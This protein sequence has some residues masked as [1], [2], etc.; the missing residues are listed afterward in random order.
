MR[1]RTL[2]MA[3]AG[4][5]LV[6][7]GASIAVDNLGGARAEGEQ[8]QDPI[9]VPQSTAEVTKKDLDAAVKAPGKLGFAEGRK[10]SSAGSGVLTWI[11]EG[12]KQVDRGGKLYEVDAKGVYLMIG[13]KPMYRELKLGNKGE[14]V[15]QLKQN[16]KALGH[17]PDLVADDEFTPGTRVAVQNWQEDHGLKQTG[18][19]GPEQIV[20]A[21]GPLRAGKPEAALGD[22]LAPGKPVYTASGAERIAEMQVT[23][24]EAGQRKVGDKVTVQLPDGSTAPGKI[25]SVGT[26]AEAPD[27]ETGGG[28]G[29]GKNAK[30]TITIELDKPG[31]VKGVDQAPVTVSMSGESRQDVLSVPVQALIALPGQGFGVQVVKD[32]KVSDL[33]VKLGLFANGRVEISGSGIS[34][35]TKVVVP[36]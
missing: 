29:G 35:G 31:Q 6:T 32:G 22:R 15:R 2:A 1:R 12:G 18:R 36:K 26:S 20:F 24:S 10:I 25:S 14:D 27:E 21:P 33:P 7:A 3:A 28:D 19:I 23:A 11:P 5:L 17:G 16:L 9:G 13:K 4:A 8:A 34:E 30:I